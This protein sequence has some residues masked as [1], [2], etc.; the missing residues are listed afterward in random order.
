MGVSTSFDLQAE[1]PRANG[2]P[3]VAYFFDPEVYDVVP[4]NWPLLKLFRL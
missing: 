2:W 3:F 1:H 4:A